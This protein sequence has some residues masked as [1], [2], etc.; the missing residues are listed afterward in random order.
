MIEFD[1]TRRIEGDETILN[2]L[3][4]VL[5]LMIILHCLGINYRDF[6][7][8]QEEK[9]PK[10][11]LCE[12]FGISN[13]TFN[14]EFKELIETLNL[15]G[16]K[17]YSLKA[18]EEFRNKWV[19]SNDIFGRTKA[20]R[21]TEIGDVLFNGNNKKLADEFGRFIG[22]EEYKKKDKLSPRIVKEFIVHIDLQDSKEAK[23]LLVL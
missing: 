12:E 8:L 16:K 15:K 9:I 17:K 7:C 6:F 1:N 20:F 4:V 18:A 21:K 22:K 3:A 10:K 19:G 23:R 11:Q 14:N 2:V 13:N 5:G